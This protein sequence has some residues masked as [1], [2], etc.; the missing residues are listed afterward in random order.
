MHILVVENDR[1]LAGIV[2]RTLEEE[3]NTVSTCFDGRAGLRAAILAVR[4]RRDRAGRDAAFAWT[5][6]R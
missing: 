1:D 2:S 3:G 4:L 5:A 6:W